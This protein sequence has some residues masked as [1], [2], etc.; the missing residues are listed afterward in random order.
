MLKIQSIFQQMVYILGKGKKKTPLQIL[1][2]LR[3]HDLCKSKLLITNLNHMGAGIS[4]EEV[5]RI[6]NGLAFYSVWKNKDTVPLPS[7]FRS[8]VWT[9]ASMDNFDHNECTL[10]GLGT[11]H[12]TV[13]ALFQEE[14]LETVIKK[15]KISETDYDQRSKKFDID[16]DCQKLLEFKGNN[17]T[18]KLPDDYHVNLKSRD[19]VTQKT[20]QQIRADD[21]A[22]LLSRM[23]LDISSENM[24]FNDIQII[25]G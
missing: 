8:D 6:K 1:L 9:L 25:P 4:Y 15:P 14:S 20:Y 16:L 5:E 17:T 22:W 2:P 24:C 23:N 11:T 10:S 3:V 13:F 21:L 7:H 12:D 19:T 18:I